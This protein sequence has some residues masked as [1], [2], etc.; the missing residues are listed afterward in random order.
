M[1]I[2]ELGS[3][4]MYLNMNF[5]YFVSIIYMLNEIKCFSPPVVYLIKV[6]F[7]IFWKTL[8]TSKQVEKSG[9][10]FEIFK[11]AEH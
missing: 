4:Q 8:N 6:Y 3:S 9:H 7:Y 2:M 5:V 1:H 11:N 10:S